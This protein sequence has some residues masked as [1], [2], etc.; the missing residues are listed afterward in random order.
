MDADEL[1]V[2]LADDDLFVRTALGGY[3]SAAPGLRLAGLC[4]NG[5]DAVQFVARERIDVFLMDI[6]MPV[7][8]GVSATRGVLRQSPRTKVLMLTSFDDEASVKAALAAGA[9]GYL[10]KSSSPEALIDAVRAVHSGNSVISPDQLRLLAKQTD[11]PH[12]HARLTDSELRVVRL[13]CQGW[14]NPRIASELYLSEST[15]KLRLAS[16][17]TKLGTTTRVATALRAMQLGLGEG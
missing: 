11:A 12:P 9:A 13:L 15:V 2:A 3:L 14:S 8:D 4:E 16:I 7:L 17:G 10:L 1:V 6:K 5:E